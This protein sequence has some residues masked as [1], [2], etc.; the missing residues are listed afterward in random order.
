[1]LRKKPQWVVGVLVGCSWCIRVGFASCAEDYA[2]FRIPC[3]QGTPNTFR[4]GAHS[5][6]RK[7]MLGLLDEASQTIECCVG[8][9]QGRVFE[10]GL[11][12]GP[13]L[14]RLLHTYPTLAERLAT[15]LENNPAA[16]QYGMFCSPPS[17]E[18]ETIGPLALQEVL[19]KR[20]ARFS[21]EEAALAIPRGPRAGRRGWS[22]RSGQPKM[23]QPQELPEMET[24][25]LVKETEVLEMETEVL[26]KELVS[27]DEI[28]V[29][30]VIAGLGR[31]GTTSLHQSLV[32]HPNIA[33]T[34]P[35]EDYKIFAEGQSNRFLPT[36]QTARALQIRSSQRGQP[37]LLGLRNPAISLY[38]LSYYTIFLQER[39]KMIL[40]LC[41]PLSR[42]E[43]QFMWFHYCH[44]DV[45]A[46]EAR[47]DAIPR[48]LKSRND[49]DPSIH[50]LLSSR[51]SAWLRSQMI[52][53]HLLELIKLFRH[54]RLFVLHRASLN[55]RKT[56]ST[57][58][59]WLQAPAFPQTWNQMRR[60]NFR[61]GHRTDLCHNQTLQVLLKRRLAPEYAAIQFALRWQSRTFQQLAADRELMLHISRCDK[62]E[63]LVEGPCGLYD[64]EEQGCPTW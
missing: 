13:Y 43:K 47:K 58:A 62:E 64:L 15:I 59:E 25:V 18:E 63:E 32:S 26:V 41:D 33:F 17:C 39:M 44:P 60:V 7:T 56:Y 30:F 36:K 53:L 38:P 5:G 57:L 12:V 55:D 20:L 29:D 40:V 46:A 45:E 35:S 9:L 6:D 2:T 16:I 42:I 37:G 61:L 21:D 8:V 52:H 1:M 4:P 50:A 24:E 27:W 49:C 19:L 11:K 22:N 51:H 34:S 3:L 23:E 14:H 31:C 28:G 48:V 54:E 10:V